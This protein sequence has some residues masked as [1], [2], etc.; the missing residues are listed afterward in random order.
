MNK[1]ELM[2]IQW[3][4]WREFRIATNTRMEDELEAIHSSSIRVLVTL[5]TIDNAND[6][7]PY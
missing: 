3:A 7:F 2:V 4:F 6:P 1:S 5:N